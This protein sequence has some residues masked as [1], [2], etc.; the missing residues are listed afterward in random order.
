MTPPTLRIELVNQTSSNAVF[1]HI[2]G[3]DIAQSNSWIIMRSDG[4]PFY[5]HSPSEILQ[6]LGAD[7]GI[8]LGDPGSSKVVTIPRIAGGRI[9]FS[10]DKPLTF[11]LNPGPALVE[12]SPTNPSD[13]NYNTSWHFCEFTFNDAQLFANI[14]CVDFAALPV[15]LTIKTAHGETTHVAGT[16]PDGLAEICAALKDQHT[17]DGAGWDSLIVKAN[18]GQLLRALSPNNGIVLNGNLFKDYW[19][20]YIDD[21]WSKYAGTDLMVDT[22][23]AAGKVKGRNVSGNELN[24]SAGSYARPSARDIFGCSSGP[25]T[26]GGNPDR[27]AITPR[28]AAAFNRSTLHTH[29]EQPCAEAVEQ[30]Y[31]H[32]VTNHYAR[33]IHEV[34][35]DRRG[36]AFPYDDVVPSGGNGA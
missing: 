24:F 5:P 6:P 13:P 31:A 27:L 36:Y 22:Q 2:T 21:V 10:I 11:L 16:G 7:V 35:L 34:H 25:F 17:K 26:P 8:P 4:T 33:I 15:A 23:T 3:L 19:S 30:Y 20:Q 18:D 28:L 32:P 29:S 1:A 9:Y 12:P 14:S